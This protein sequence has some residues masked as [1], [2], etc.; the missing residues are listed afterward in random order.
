MKVFKQIKN[1]VVQGSKDSTG[2]SEKRQEGRR[3]Q[4]WW[5]K[6]L[7]GCMVGA[8]IVVVAS[9][10]VFAVK[11]AWWAPVK[12]LIASPLTPHKKKSRAQR[13]PNS[14]FKQA[15]SRTTVAP[16]QT[17]PGSGQGQRAAARMERP[18]TLAPEFPPATSSPST[19]PNIRPQVSIPAGPGVPGG[20]Q[21]PAVATSAPAFP[22]KQEE[23][24]LDEYLEIGTLYAQ[25]GA[26]EKAEEL[27]QRVTKENPSSAQARNNL[28][29]VY[30]KQE[31]YEKAEGEFKEAVRINPAFV[32]PYYNLACLY[33]RKGMDVEAL[34]Y[35][36]RALNRDARVKLWAATDEDFAGL[37]S[38]VV[39]QELMG[40]PPP[41]KAEAQKKEGVQ[42]EKDVQ[43]REQPQQ[44]APHGHPQPE[45]PATVTPV[46][47]QPAT[48]KV[49]N[50]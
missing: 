23:S 1:K 4:P 8:S 36:K 35:L 29:F 21:G 41:P 28:G 34:I 11:P 14:V 31:E 38:D 5:K 44:A 16:P 27:F 46:D 50:R 12:G 20:V 49:I 37:R 18:Q 9:W 22:A 10:V 39:F 26:Y 13:P 6:A 30:L 42:G 2:A 40:I 47:I 32:L 25:K 7:L 15:E 48:Q 19:S 45:G 33:S 3:P 24:A 17:A 43:T